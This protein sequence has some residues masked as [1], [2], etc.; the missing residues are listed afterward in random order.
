MNLQTT[1]APM[2]Y[3]MTNFENE[4]RPVNTG[5]DEYQHLF[6]CAVCGESFYSIPSCDE[7]CRDEFIPRYGHAPEE[8]DDDELVSLCD[9]CNA[10]YERIKKSMM[11]ST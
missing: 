9:E 1:T 7:E 11:I 8:T 10:E 5:P 4:I 2:G 3:A 6:T